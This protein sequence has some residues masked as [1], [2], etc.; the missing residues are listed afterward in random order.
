MSTAGALTLFLAIAVDTDW[1][2]PGGVHLTQL[3]R[4]AIVTP[5]NNFLYNFDTSNLAKHGLH[6]YYQHLVVNLPQLLGVAFPLH[7]LSFRRNTQ[8]YSA[9]CG[10]LVLSC[11]RHQEARFLIPTVPLILSSI[12]LPQ[13]FTRVWIAVWIIFNAVLGVLMGIYH[14]GG[15]VPAQLWIGTQHNATQALWWKT[16]NPPTYL[17]GAGSEI[18]TTDLMGM[19][20]EVMVKTVS[21]SVQC[22]ANAS[23]LLVA[24]HSATYLDPYIVANRARAGPESI[25]LE[26]VWT[27]RNHL[28]LDDMDFGDD[29]IWPTL[30]RVI[31][32]R[33]LGVWKVHKQC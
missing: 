23:I 18:T 28:N 12:N 21:E 6:P 8:F 33:G 31:G 26:Q 22:G 27:Y 5:L 25:S 24:P 11:F 1:Y 3:H 29:G 32:R 10:I 20:G 13:R 17:L 2:T 14:Q 19:R 7:L 30:S 16:Y 4:T 15:V 9:V